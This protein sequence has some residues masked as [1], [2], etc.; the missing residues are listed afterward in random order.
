MPVKPIRKM[1][2]EYIQWLIENS[3]RESDCLEFKS[4]L[5]FGTIDEE[6]ELLADVSAFANSGGGNII[7]GIEEGSK[8][9]AVSICGVPEFSVDQDIAAIM[10]ILEK[11]LSRPVPGLDF[12]IITKEDSDPVVVIHIP[13]SRRVPYSVGVESNLSGYFIRRSNIRHV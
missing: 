6:Y 8:G 3:I 5:K 2:L 4:E 12:R 1:N 13:F 11:G 10:A 7:Y 9:E